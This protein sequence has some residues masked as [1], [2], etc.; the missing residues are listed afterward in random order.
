MR[1]LLFFAVALSVAVLGCGNRQVPMGGK[2][3]F[4][5]TGEPLSVGTVAF[6]D[7]VSQAVSRINGDGTY[8]L[9]FLKERD[10]LPKGSYRVYIT[11]AL[12]Y[13]HGPSSPGVSLL[14][15]KFASASTSGLSVTVDGSTKVFD[16]QV[17]RAPKKK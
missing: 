9:G 4:S 2:I 11:D 6:T 10:G 14:A 12:E 17:E 16:F 1:F 3:T 8:E 15:P 5:D 7:G 13:P